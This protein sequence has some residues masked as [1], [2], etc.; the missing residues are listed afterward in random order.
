MLPDMGA[1]DGKII[2]MLR[3]AGCFRGERQ[4]FL[5][6]EDID[7]RRFSGIGTAG[8]SDLRNVRIRQ[9]TEMIDRGEEAG[10]PKL[11]H[12]VC[13]KCCKVGKNAGKLLYNKGLC[14]VVQQMQRCAALSRLQA[15]RAGFQLL[16]LRVC[17]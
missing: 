14:T 13:R 17:E 2:D 6:A 9:I 10:L 1:A 4:F 16:S 7:R 11:G 15:I 5:V 3:S 12:S 8:K